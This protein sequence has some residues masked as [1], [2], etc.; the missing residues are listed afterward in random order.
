MSEHKLNKTEFNERKA[1]REE[2][3]KSR[4][5]INSVAGLRARVELLETVLGVK[6]EE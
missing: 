3:K 6:P 4:G 1:A 5:N 2:L